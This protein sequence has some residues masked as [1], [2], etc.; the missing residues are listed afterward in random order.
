MLK[1]SVIYFKNYLLGNSKARLTLAVITLGLLSSCGGDSGGQLNTV[2]PSLTSSTKKTLNFSGTVAIGDALKEVIVTATCSD[3]SSGKSAPTNADGAY[4]LGVLG[5]LPCAFSVIEPKTGLVL[6]SLSATDG[7]VNL[8]PLTEAIYVFSNGDTAKVID[9]KSRLTLLMNAIGSPLKVDPISFSFMPDRT[10]LDKNILDFADAAILATSRQGISIGGKTPADSLYESIV[11]QCTDLTNCASTESFLKDMDTAQREIAIEI[12]KALDEDL[13]VG[14]LSW[15]FQNSFSDTVLKTASE[16]AVKFGISYLIK[17]EIFAKSFRSWSLKGLGPRKLAKE[18]T[19]L[20]KENLSKSILDVRK[21][22]KVDLITN[23]VFS[24]VFEYFDNK[25]LDY[26][27]DGSL[28]P[29]EF[30]FASAAYGIAS[31]ALETALKA[32]VSCVSVPAD[33]ICKNPQLAFARAEFEVMIDRLYKYIEVIPEAVRLNG[34]WLFGGG[35]TENAERTTKFSQDLALRLEALSSDAKAIAIGWAKGGR[36][37]NLEWSIG[38]SVSQKKAE[39]SALLADSFYKGLE[40]GTR[41]QLVYSNNAR[42]DRLAS[43]YS[44]LAQIC[45]TAIDQK[46]EIGVSECLNLMNIQPMA[47]LSC[48]SPLVLKGGIC[49]TTGPYSK[50]ATNGT[51]LEDS[52]VPRGY[53]PNDWACTRNNTTGLIY[54]LKMETGLRARS[55][56]YTNFDSTVNRQNIDSNGNLVSAT[57]AEIDAPTNSIGLIKSLNA[58]KLC[59]R[60]DWRIPNNVEGFFYPVNSENVSYFPDVI[61]GGG[62]SAGIPYTTFDGAPI[63]LREE[64]PFSV[65]T[66]YYSYTTVCGRI[67][68]SSYGCL[69]NGLPRYE[70]YLARGVSG[71]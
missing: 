20:M 29:T 15:Y 63:W 22:N 65:G 16:R 35:S 45:Q 6:R 8:T 38:L 34:F 60:S 40:P 26:I 39:N 32:V 53:G 61:V 12:F 3:A 19:S 21:I 9:A 51:L 47:A 24:S 46:G 52:V 67:G 62:V 33:P 2:T 18:I 10:G 17:N 30:F 48:L 66:S 57:Q 54:E 69:L 44:K 28:S 7:T 1:C 50:I 43:R 13:F 42:F 71:G 55:L 27:T 23:A 4:S 58:Q 64:Y 68:Y 49:V 59:G 31:P 14:S 25:A 70:K 36:Q 41:Q 11:A 5:A 37:T 56:Q